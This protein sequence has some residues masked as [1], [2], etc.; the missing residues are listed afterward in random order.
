VAGS[1]F[2]ARSKN[3]R[4][5]LSPAGKPRSRESVEAHKLLDADIPYGPSTY[6]VVN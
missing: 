5:G 1:R 4:L 3:V 2:L 6:L